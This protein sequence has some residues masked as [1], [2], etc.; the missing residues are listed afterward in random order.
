MNRRELYVGDGWSFV[1]VPIAPS[2]SRYYVRRGA[3]TKYNRGFRTR[4]EVDA[5]IE[6]FGDMLEE[7]DAKILRIKLKGDP[8]DIFIVRRNGEVYER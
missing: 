7:Q 5:W 1:L 3:V 4:I 2:Y 6:S 8:V